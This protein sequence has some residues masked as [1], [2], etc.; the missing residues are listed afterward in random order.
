[1]QLKDSSVPAARCQLPRQSFAKTSDFDSGSTVRLKERLPRVDEG[2]LRQPVGGPGTR[3]RQ[4]ASATSNQ[5]AS[6]EG[7]ADRETCVS[8]RQR[9]S[10]EFGA[11]FGRPRLGEPDDLARS[12]PF[13]NNEFDHPM[14]S[15][16]G[17]DADSGRVK[18]LANGPT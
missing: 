3:S 13:G 1:M 6:A 4:E 14:H 9:P 2:Y 18:V 7:P 15:Q 17:E 10:S 12:K 5:S 11:S 8:R 16:L